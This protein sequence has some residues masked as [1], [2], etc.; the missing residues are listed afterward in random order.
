[1]KN[2]VFFVLVLIVQNLYSQVAIDNTDINS[3]DG[4]WENESKIISL[5]SNEDGSIDADIV[6]KTFYGYYYD[7]IFPVEESV[8]INLARFEDSL[9]IDYWMQSKAYDS[10]GNAIGQQEEAEPFFKV[11]I[12]KPVQFDFSTALEASGTLWL[13][14]SNT[15]E[16][17]IDS[18]IIKNEVY[19][20]YIDDTSTYMIRYWLTDMPYT[21]EKVDLKL[22]QREEPKSVYIDKYI[23]IG[24]YVYTSA[25]GLRTEIRNI[26]P[27]ESFGEDALINED[28]S[29]LVF[30]QP[31]LELSDISNVEDAVLAHNS[32]IR[33]P[34]DGRAKFVEPSIYKKL[35]QMTIEDFDNP[36]APIH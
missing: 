4:I 8:P 7:G 15:H 9:Y 27:I 34:R 16:L 26:T 30:G 11:K 2:V 19:A 14:K 35:E 6:L 21:D 32:I 18:T 29:I 28:N 17:S 12:E 5:T 31:Y 3:I 20:Y 24:N 1:M 13:P 36:Y 22:I 25:T 33:P 10:L 23:Q